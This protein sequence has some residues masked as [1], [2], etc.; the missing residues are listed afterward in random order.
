MPA[1]HPILKTQESVLNTSRRR[2]APHPSKSHAGGAAM[3]NARTLAYL[4]RSR[5]EEDGGERGRRVGRAA[6]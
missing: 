1:A 3:A 5:R 4:R 6:S 2:I